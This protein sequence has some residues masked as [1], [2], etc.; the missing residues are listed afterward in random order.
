MLMANDSE[1]VFRFQ[2]AGPNDSTLDC[3]VLAP[4]EAAASAI[5]RKLLGDDLEFTLCTSWELEQNPTVLPGL[6]KSTPLGIGPYVEKG[7]RLKSV[8]RSE[9]RSKLSSL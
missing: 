9:W 6:R 8:P 3:L 7:L 4:D 1:F 5:M 2:P